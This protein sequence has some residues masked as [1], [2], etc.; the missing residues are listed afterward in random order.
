M[1]GDK[2]GKVTFSVICKS[3]Y[4]QQRKKTI[5]PKVFHNTQPFFFYLTTKHNGERHSKTTDSPLL[6]NNITAAEIFHVK[7]GDQGS[8]WSRFSYSGEKQ[9][10]ERISYIKNAMLSTPASSFFMLMCHIVMIY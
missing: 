2:V 10:R 9:T 4:T 7:G 8:R 1:T 6:V 3:G 5:L